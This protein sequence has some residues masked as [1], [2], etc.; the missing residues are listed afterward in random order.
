[1]TKRLTPLEK[2]DRKIGRIKATLAK[3]Q[4]ERDAILSDTLIECMDFSPNDRGCGKSTPVKDL[5]YIHVEEY[6]SPYSCNGGDYWVRRP[7]SAFFVCPCG[8]KN[9]L[10]DREDVRNLAAY[11]KEQQTIKQR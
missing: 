11:F 7:R 1:M 3:A 9:R 10:Y 5:V 8:Q 4:D 6:I 2:V